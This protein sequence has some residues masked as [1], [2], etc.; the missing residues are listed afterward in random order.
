MK[1]NDILYLPFIQP[2]DMKAFISILIASTC[3]TSCGN[4]QGTK[5]SQRLIGTCEGCEAIFEY[6]E[7]KL[8]PVDTLPDFADDGIKIKV[9]GIMY[10]AQGAPAK[11]VVLYV[12]HTNQQGVYPTKGNEKGWDKRHGY[13]R[14]W[15]KTDEKGQYTFYT[16]KPQPY[17]G[18]R[19]PAHIHPTI[20]EPDGKY[21]W[22]DEYLFAGD[23]LL[24]RNQD[25]TRQ[26]RGG[27]TGILEL[28]KEGDIW[29]AKRDIY[30]GRNVPGYQ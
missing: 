21:Y 6:G 27:E 26:P 11:D 9:S 29:V 28:K 13:I 5:Y 17:P 23:T 16:L 2:N 15:M 3:F 20:L 7:K 10:D 18:R 1:T 22:I 8:K 14:G 30:L 12:Y 24:K 25:T 19:D 4:T